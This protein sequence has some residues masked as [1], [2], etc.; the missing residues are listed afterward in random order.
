M[1]GRPRNMG[2]CFYISDITLL[3]EKLLQFDWLRA[4]VFRL[5]LKYLHVKITN[6]LRVA[7]ERGS[8]SSLF[9]PPVITTQIFDHSRNG[10]GGQFPRNLH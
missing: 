5:N 6:L 8:L 1:Q 4:V 9:R 3:H 10:A 2:N 7:Q